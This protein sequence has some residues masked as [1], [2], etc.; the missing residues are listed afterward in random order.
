MRWAFLCLA[1]SLKIPGSISYSI[2]TN[3]IPSDGALILQDLTVPYHPPIKINDTGPSLVRRQQAGRCGPDFGGHI[4]SNDQCCSFFGYC[5]LGQDHCSQIASCQPAYG[6]CE[7]EQ[8]PTPSTTSLLTTATLTLST[9]STSRTTNGTSIPLPSTT[10][11]TS[12]TTDT[13]ATLPPTTS[14]TSTTPIVIATPT[15]SSTSNFPP[16]PTGT[17]VSRDG[18]C[19]NS[20]VCTGSTFGQCCSPYWYCGNS[21][22]YCGVGCNPL[23]GSCGGI[24]SLSSSSWFS[25][26][27]VVVPSSSSSTIVVPPTISTTSTTSTTSTASTTSS[28]STPPIVLTTSTRTSNSTS[29]TRPITTPTPTPT[30]GG[31][32]TTKDGTCGNGFSCNGWADGPCCSRFGYCGG[33]Y[34]YCRR[35]LGCQL[36]FGT[37]DP[38]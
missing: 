11:L 6:Y 30:P 2:D 10:S 23:Y 21:A 9:T 32:P 35:L 7:G 26:S 18:M 3:L 38:T 5:G 28:S 24:G 37:C 34:L 22:E 31:L 1:A 15:I 14:S 12:S 17:L 20:T 4:C 13:I 19:G 27:T 29:S 25:L 36:A 8:L 33:D 16:L